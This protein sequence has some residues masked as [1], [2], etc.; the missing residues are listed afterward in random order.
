MGQS[1][2]YF[3]KMREKEYSELSTD[4]KLYLNK[5]GII[6]KHVPSKEDEQDE[7]VK[8]FDKAIKKA[9]E[10]RDKYLFKKRNK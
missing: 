4:E 3:L 6:T 2:E 8:D 5:L 1:K 10:E 9:Y 7:K